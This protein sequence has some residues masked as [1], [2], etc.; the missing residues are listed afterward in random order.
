MLRFICA[1]TFFIPALMIASELRPFTTDGCSSFPDG[2]L[3]QRTLWHNCCVRHDIEYWKGGTYEGR[4]IA[5]KKLE[6]CVTR[7]GEPN[8]AKLMLAGV[9]VGGSPY[10]PTPYRWGYGWPYFRDYGPLNDAEQLQ[11]QKKLNE[12]NIMKKNII[13]PSEEKLSK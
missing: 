4:I 13:E 8:I 11:V 2:T 12:L 3:Q 1:L 7:V 9:R 10:W 5:D 6:Q